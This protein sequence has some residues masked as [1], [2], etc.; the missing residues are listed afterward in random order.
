MTLPWKISIRSKILIVLSTVVILAVALYLYLASKIFY[1]DKTLLIY[2]LNQTNV[3]TLGSDVETY[4]KRVLDKLRTVAVLG[5]SSQQDLDRVLPIM[6]GDD[7]GFIR[8]GVFQPDSAGLL[9]NQTLASWNDPLK[10]YSKDAT[11]LDEVHRVFPV[12]VD[13]V[14]AD[15]TWVKNVTLPGEESPPIM[16]VAIALKDTLGVTRIVYA[17]LTLDHLA[18]AFS[19]EGVAK[20]YLIDSDAG[21]LVRSE[22]GHPTEDLRGDPLL[23]AARNSKVRS[24]VRKFEDGDRTYLGSFFKVGVAGIVVGSKIESGEA[25]TAARLLVRKSLLYALIVITAAFLVALFLSHSITEPIERLVMATEQVAKGDF[26]QQVRITS[27]DEISVLAKSFNTMTIHLKYSRKEIEEYSKTLEKKV[28]DR[29]AKL[30]AQTVAIR[31]TQEALVRTTR[32]ASVGE[33]AGRAAHE[34]LNPLTNITARLEKIRTQDIQRDNQDLKLLQEITEAWSKSFREGGGPALLMA[35]SGNSTAHPGKTLLEEDLMNLGDVAKDSLAQVASRQSDVDFLL[36][37]CGRISKIVNGMRQLTRVSGSRRQV[38][39]H[40][41]LN[42]ALSSMGDLFSKNDIQIEKSLFS[43]SPSI[44][45]DHDE[46]LQVLSNLFRN[47]MQAIQ[48]HRRTNGSP[49]NPAKI[50]VA[51]AV[52]NGG[53]T[54][55]V[56]IRI[57]DNGPGVASGDREQIFEPTFTTKSIEEGT[58]L[59]LSIARRFIRAHEGE[60]I[61]EKSEP[62]VET[63]FLIELPEASEAKHAS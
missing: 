42:E 9:Q 10:I 39:V 45:A 61:L 50:S 28:A 49:K 33:V 46:L 62:G 36:K 11:Y 31:E 22:G 8:I 21:V 40:D 63:V 18:K 5:V 26:E 60:I 14:T 20:T 24:E 58:G 6:I 41:L 48:E 47:S 13:K 57:G 51:T 12:P 56:Q 2:E 55:R 23:A 43:G 32:L 19:R 17:D 44:Y 38:G 37:E 4:L 27:R 3:Q 25:F 7:E 52:V 59:G 15:G 34:V 35:L 30:E 1:E 29:T 53:P 54:A 16:T